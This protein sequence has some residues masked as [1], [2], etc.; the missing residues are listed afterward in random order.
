MT[1]YDAR[2]ARFSREL[3]QQQ[4]AISRLRPLAEGGIPGSQGLRATVWKVSHLCRTS[5]LFCSATAAQ[6][7]LAVQLLLGYL[8]TDRHHWDRTLA[9]KRALYAQFCQASPV[10]CAQCLLCPV[11]AANKALTVAS[12]A[13]ADHQPQQSSG[14]DAAWR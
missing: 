13:G 14:R 10:C 7:P 3:E 8:P 6:C 1:S 11:S 12:S 4:I 5:S 9:Q 2:L